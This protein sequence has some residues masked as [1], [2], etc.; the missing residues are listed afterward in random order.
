MKNGPDDKVL[1]E[2][3]TPNVFEFKLNHNK[4][5]NSIDND[6]INIITSMLQFWKA[7]P[8]HNPRVALISG[9][10]GKAFCAGGDIV[11]LY[12]GNL[13]QKG[14]D[15]NVKRIFFEKEYRMDYQLT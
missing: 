12:H 6:M 4:T 9:T 15:A 10:G 13:N 8:E 14:L 11:S 5:L 7:K 2:Y 3:M 1:L